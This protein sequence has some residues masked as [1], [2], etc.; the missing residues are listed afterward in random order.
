LPTLARMG[1]IVVRALKEDRRVDVAAEARA[2][3]ISRDWKP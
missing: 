2:A 3:L 1:W